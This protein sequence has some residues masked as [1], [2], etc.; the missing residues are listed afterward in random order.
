MKAILLRGVVVSGAERRAMRIFRALRAEGYPIALYV[1]GGFLDCARS[2]LPEFAD[3]IRVYD[4]YFPGSGAV[5]RVILRL[6]PP[7]RRPASSAWR[8]LKDRLLDRRLRR[9]GVDVCHIFLDPSIGARLSIRTIIEATS[10]DYV[11]TLRRFDRYSAP[12][13]IFNG[14]S[15]SVCDRLAAYLPPERIGR[16]PIAFFDDEGLDVVDPAVGKEN[17]VVFAHR[18]IRRKNGA[19]FAR[20][21]RAFLERHPDWRAAVLGAGEDEAAIAETLGDLARAGRVELGHRDSIFPYLARSRIFVSVTTPNNY[22]SQSVLEALHFG[23]ALLLSDTGTSVARFL[24]GNGVACAVE[25]ASMLEGLERLAA[26]PEALLAMGRRSQAL[27]KARYD[28]SVYLTYL[29]ALYA[30]A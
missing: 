23:N 4:D 26:D 12:R 20:A 17:L 25:E 2:R 21:C 3:E 29:K 19:L 9:D 7:L 1:A 15:E 5:T 13:P 10:P 11:E 14:V 30:G 18:L 27:V 24:D 8:A 16:P 6:P 22:P 28:K